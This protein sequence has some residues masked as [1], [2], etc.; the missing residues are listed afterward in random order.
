VNFFVGI[1]PVNRLLV[2]DGSGTFTDES[3]TKL[4]TTLRNAVDADFVDMDADGDLDLLVGSVL[5]LQLLLNEGD[6]DFVDATRPLVRTDPG[7]TIFDIEPADYNGDGR[8]D[9][10]FSDFFGDDRILIAV[11]RPI[12]WEIEPA[13]P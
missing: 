6:G 12:F 5:G 11:E 3:D 13:K 10:Y 7:A 2:N 1:T 4:P 9:L 8:P